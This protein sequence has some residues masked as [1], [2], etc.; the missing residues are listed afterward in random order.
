MTFANAHD[1][2]FK[3]HPACYTASVHRRDAQRA[4]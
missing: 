1:P 3:A 4:E 2:L